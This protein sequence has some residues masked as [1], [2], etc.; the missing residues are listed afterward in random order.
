MHRHT[1]LYNC[2]C[3]TIKAPARAAP[4][5]TTQNTQQRSMLFRPN[6]QLKT[7]TTLH[8]RTHAHVI[9]TPLVHQT[10][11]EHTERSNS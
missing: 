1:H 3:L 11:P 2:R 8:T 9:R 7:T 4:E 5:K 6:L 10:G